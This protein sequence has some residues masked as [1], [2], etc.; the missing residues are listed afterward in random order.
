MDKVQ[1]NTEYIK[2]DSLLKFA[3]VVSSGGEAKI[4]IQENKILV[5][6]QPENRRGRKLYAGDVVLCPDGEF[7]VC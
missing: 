3:N 2:L 1:I 4:Y 5:N 6:N 7:H